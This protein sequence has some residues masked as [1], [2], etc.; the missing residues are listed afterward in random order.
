MNA[1][2]AMNDEPI[3]TPMYWDF[4]DRDEAYEVPNQYR[5]GSEL[6]VAPITQPRNKTTHLGAIK[7]WFPPHRYVDVFTGMV[8]DGDRRFQLHRPLTQTPVLAPEGAI[9]PLDAAWR[10]KSGSPNPEAIEIL[11]VVGADGSFDLLE[12]NGTGTYVTDG[13]FQIVESGSADGEA[14][15]GVHLV[16]T[17]ITYKQDTG[18][19]TIGPAYPPNDPSIP[20]TREWKVRL[21]AYTP[22]GTPS[23]AAFRCITTCSK[24]ARSLPYSVET[25]HNGTLITLAAIS[26]AQTCIIELPM[27]S[28]ATGPQ[29]DIVDPVPRIT[30]DLLLHANMYLDKKWQILNVVG[31]ERKSVLQKVTDLQNMQLEESL[32]NAILELLTADSRY[33]SLGVGDFEIC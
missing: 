11:L 24:R 30:N 7:M 17:P 9:I 32:L 19:I 22:T 21:I 29:L 26:S 2:S 28:S 8:Y 6:L 13:G 27:T 5:F 1:R 25:V 23:A 4:A 12:D 16:T 31:D 18:V 10:P 3:V 33:Q 14:D 15:E 20:Q